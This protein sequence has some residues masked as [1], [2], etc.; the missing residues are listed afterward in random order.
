MAAR[1]K[2]GLINQPL[3]SSAPDLPFFGVFFLL[4]QVKF[5]LEALYE[6]LNRYELGASESTASL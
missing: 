5:A 3:P 1:Q 6:A 4:A 2:I